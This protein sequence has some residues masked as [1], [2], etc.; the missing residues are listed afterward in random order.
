MAGFAWPNWYWM[1]LSGT[2]S[3]VIST[4]CAA[5]MVRGNR[6]RTPSRTAVIVGGAGS[7]MPAPIA[8]SAR[9]GTL[10]STACEAG[11][12]KPGSLAATTGPALSDACGATGCRTRSDRGGGPMMPLLLRARCARRRSSAACLAEH[13]TRDVAD[14]VSG[15]D[16]AMT[17]DTLS[18]E[19]GN[20]PTG[21]EL[22]RRPLPS[23]EQRLGGERE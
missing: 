4:V 9:T 18:R 15:C 6:R 5:K 11:W 21:F 8:A 3:R 12:S 7:A 10:R 16:G 23:R 14:A 13:T 17:K 22:S 20:D 19:A 2:P 1:T